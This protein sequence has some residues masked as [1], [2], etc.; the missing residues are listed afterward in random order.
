M[1]YLR[2]TTILALVVIALTMSASFAQDRSKSCLNPSGYSGSASISI[3]GNTM[4]CDQYLSGVSIDGVVKVFS[5]YENTTS[6]SYKN[7][8]GV[9]SCS[10]NSF[11]QDQR[12]K[13][14]EE[15]FQTGCCNGKSICYQNASRFCKD[16]SQFNASNLLSN[17]GQPVTCMTGIPHSFSGLNFA[18]LTCADLSYSQKQDLSNRNIG[19]GCC[20]DGKDLCHGV[21]YSKMCINPSSYNGSTIFTSPGGSASCDVH[22][23]NSPQLANVS[24]NS[25]TCAGLTTAEKNAISTYFKSN[26]CTDGRDL[27]FDYSKTCLNP[28]NY[29]GAAIFTSPNGA[30]ACDVQVSTNP[31]LTSVNWTS[32]TC[33]GLTTGQKQ[34]MSVLESNCCTD[35]KGICYVAPTTTASPT[36]TSA[37][38]V[39]TTTSAAVA[40]TTTSNTTAN[41]ELDTSN[42]ILTSSSNIVILV[43]STIVALAAH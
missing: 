14:L 16:P 11:T 34:V 8:T 12:F 21:D 37:A 29:N 23:S 25:I 10:S 42:G 26:C 40:A 22:A 30:A 3:Y 39:A 17:S 32:I 18:T 19:A 1:L 6:P 38:A 7:W 13:L 31:D 41:D 27:C 43:L 20:M 28:S 35:G 5:D 36:T 33:A 9:T 15:P 2:T 24:W 4:T